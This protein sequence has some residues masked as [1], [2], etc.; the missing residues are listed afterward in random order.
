MPPPSRK[1]PGL[2]CRWSRKIV[3]EHHGEIE[4]CNMEGG[5]ARICVRLPVLA[6]G[7]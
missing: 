4:V 2:G 6:E 3:E 1:G 7:K 5:G